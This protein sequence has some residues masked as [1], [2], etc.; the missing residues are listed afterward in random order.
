[1]D[2]VA[3]EQYLDAEKTALNPLYELWQHQK[4]KDKNARSAPC[5][6]HLHAMQLTQRFAPV[7]LPGCCVAWLLCMLC[8]Y[9]HGHC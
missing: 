2:A 1:M 7:V 3:P 5:Y 4:D 9:S 6:K 8:Q